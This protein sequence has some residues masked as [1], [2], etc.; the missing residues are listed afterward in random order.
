MR[1]FYKHLALCSCASV[2]TGL[3]ISCSSPAHAAADAL[4]NLTC[5]PVAQ[6]LRDLGCWILKAE[7]QGRIS[8]SPVYWH[9]YAYDTPTLAESAK[10]S[11][12]QTVLESLGR[13]WL[14]TIAPRDWHAKSGKPVA[15]IGPLEIDG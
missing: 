13:S 4:P 1:S 10:E 7:P 6:R 14:M 15:V 3:F 2:T 11:Q 8:D 9:L 12:H 5:Q